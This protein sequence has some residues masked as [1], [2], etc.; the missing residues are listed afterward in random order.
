MGLTNDL[1]DPLNCNSVDPVITLLAGPFR[2]RPNNWSR[3]TFKNG[4][5]HSIIVRVEFDDAS[6]LFTGDMEDKGLESVIEHYGKLENGM[7]DTDIYQV[8]H[9]GSHNA[10]SD[11][12][13]EAITPNAAII[14]CG[15]WNFGLGTNKKF[16]TYSYGHPRQLTIQLL[17]QGIRTTPA[18]GGSGTGR[19]D[20]RGASRCLLRY[21][22]PGRSRPGN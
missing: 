4:N 21:L 22:R 9:H 11:D 13:V 12:L 8:G 5:N 20:L 15:R 3:S 7:L 16:N 19:T 10:T 2:T 14:S 6:F 18:A 17:E 1:I